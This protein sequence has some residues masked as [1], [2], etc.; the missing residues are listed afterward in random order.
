MEA[1]D[2]YDFFAR[3]AGEVTRAQQHVIAD[4]A[5]SLT[6]SL[7]KE[8]AMKAAVTLT[9]VIGRISEAVAFVADLKEAADFENSWIAAMMRLQPPDQRRS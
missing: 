4:L 8:V 2:A 1:G 3:V 7:A 9:P 6:E 5:P